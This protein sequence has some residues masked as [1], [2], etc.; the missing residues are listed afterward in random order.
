[1]AYDLRARGYGRGARLGYFPQRQ[2]I[3]ALSEARNRLLR[4]SVRQRRMWYLRILASPPGFVWLLAQ[5]PPGY[6]RVHVFGI[7][8]LNIVVMCKST[9]RVSWM[10]A[11]C[12]GP[13]RGAV[14]VREARNMVRALVTLLTFIVFVVPVPLCSDVEAPTAAYKHHSSLYRWM[15]SDRVS[16]ASPM[17]SRSAMH[18]Q[19]GRRRLWRTNGFKARSLADIVY[20]CRRRCACHSS[21]LISSAAVLAVTGS[22]RDAERSHGMWS[23]SL[24]IVLRYGAG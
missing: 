11:I 14:K 18:A 19:W 15:S 8:G 24:T 17:C 2:L 7:A 10:C 4:E 20:R 1:M 22:E 5:L 13:M 9:R 12:R 6:I 16:T 3:E 21:V 23:P